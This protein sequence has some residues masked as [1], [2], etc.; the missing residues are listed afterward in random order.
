MSALSICPDCSGFVPQSAVCPHCEVAAPRTSPAL[1]VLKRS[2]RFVAAGAM[3]VTISACYGGGPV[4]TDCEVTGVEVTGD[5]AV[6]VGAELQLTAT[7]SLD[8]G[9]LMD[10]T[11]SALWESDTP[12]VATVD[13]GLVTGVSPGSATISADFDGYIG[14]AVV[15]VGTGSSL[16]I[17]TSAGEFEPEYEDAGPG[18]G[19][20]VFAG[21][22]G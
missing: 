13:A 6:V 18:S 4:C 9:T 22:G 12:A 11:L 19:S 3:T 21:D 5:N 16:T 20:E 15:T 10:V 7:A 14:T 17:I 2:L 1:R 8:D